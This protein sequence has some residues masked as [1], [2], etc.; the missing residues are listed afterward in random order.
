VAVLTVVLSVVSPVGAA[1]VGGSSPGLVGPAPGPW[2][3]VVVLR[4]GCW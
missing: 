4:T 2:G 3:L 1:W